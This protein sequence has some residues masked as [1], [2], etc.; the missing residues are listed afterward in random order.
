MLEENK[1]HWFTLHSSV[2]SWHHVRSAQEILSLPSKPESWQLEGVLLAGGGP[3]G[4]GEAEG[5]PGRRDTPERDGGQ[6]VSATGTEK[7]AWSWPSGLTPYMPTC[8]PTLSPVLKGDPVGPVCTVR[9][10]CF[11]HGSKSLSVTWAT[12]VAVTKQ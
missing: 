11:H 4:G 12:Q 2:S 3:E 1:D 8:S 10:T 5:T 7:P 9:K 6:T